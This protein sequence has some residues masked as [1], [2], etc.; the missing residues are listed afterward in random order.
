MDRKEFTEQI[1]KFLPQR[2]RSLFE[3]LPEDAFDRLQ[4]IRLRTGRP[5]NVLY[6]NEE[7][8][9][10]QAGLFF[11]PERGEVIKSED[12][13]QAILF[14]SN[15]SVYA[16]DEELRQGFITIPGG[17]RVGFVGYGVVKDGEIK[18]LKEFSG[19]NFRITREIKGSANLILPFLQRS[20]VWPT[21][22][23]G[24]GHGYVSNQHHGCVSNQYH[25]C[26]SDQHYGCI[27]DLH[28]N[29]NQSYQR[30]SGS[31]AF[32]VINDAHYNGL[33]P[34]IHHTMIISP[35]R[36]GKTTLLRDLIRQ[37][38]NGF[39]GQ[40]GMKVGVVDERSEIAGSFLGKPR[41]DLGIRTDVLD[42]CPKS[43]GMYLLIR[44]MSPQV[45][46]TDEI[47][48][49]EDVAAIQEAVNAGIR[50]ITTVHGRD[51]LELSMRPILRDL[52]ESK[53]FTRYIILSNRLGAG[54]I[55]GIYDENRQQ[56]YA[57]NT[58]SDVYSEAGC[59]DEKV[60]VD[61]DNIAYLGR[62]DRRG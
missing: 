30:T 46:A 47:G 7:Y 38:S 19:I 22:K 13:Q 41:H 55:E 58:G 11:E 36:C 39:L 5:L 34:D 10:G 2:L 24:F 48:S 15:H 42:H 32:N 27:S 52:I 43:G 62:V 12:I 54:T 35:P 18:Q 59:L 23:P 37:L 51:L 56:L 14:L 49:A 29:P 31:D 21:I 26:V 33:Y 1:V 3:L 44:S 8:F 16:L 4:E 28:Q 60:A 57:K 40:A 53:I 17:H 20:R 61:H 9:L 45:I 6:S 25:E 50:L